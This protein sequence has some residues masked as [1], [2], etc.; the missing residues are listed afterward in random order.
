M[1]DR[2]RN[3]RDNDVL[4]L[5]GGSMSTVS[6]RDLLTALAATPALAGLSGLAWGAVAAAPKYVMYEDGKYTLPPLPYPYNALE[7]SI[8]EQT[9]RLHH[10]KHHQSYVTGLNKALDSLADARTKGD[11]AL[12]KHWERELSF[13]ASG[14]F[15][16][17]LF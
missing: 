8:D 9:M 12:V 14:H 3:E 4:S 11:Y 5:Q 16:H 17:S 6:R 13:N 10:D 7:P 15:L 1:N 2:R